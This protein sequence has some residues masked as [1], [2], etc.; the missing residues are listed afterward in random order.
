MLWSIWIP[1]SDVEFDLASV[2]EGDVLVG[3]V[4]SVDAHG[5]GGDV[6]EE[7]RGELEDGG[8][9]LLGA[10]SHFAGQ[11]FLLQVVLGH[12]EGLAELLV[13]DAEDALNRG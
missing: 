2:F 7:E 9:F 6:L 11:L 8:H 5:G 13:A 4:A 3:E 12:E 10:H 1:Q